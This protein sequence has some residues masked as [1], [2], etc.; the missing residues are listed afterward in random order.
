MKLDRSWEKDGYIL[1]PAREE[2]AERYFEQNFNP[3]DREA[4]R[5]TGSKASFTRE[6]VVSFLRKAVHAEDQY[7]FLLISPDGRM[8]GESV[9]KSGLP[10]GGH[11][12]GRG[13]GR[14]QLCRRYPD[15]AA[16]RR[17]ERDK[18]R[19]VT[20]VLDINQW[21][22]QYTAAVRGAFG[23][24]IRFIG[25]QGSRG[26]G[27]AKESSDIDVVLILDRLDSEDL[28]TYRSAVEALPE[29]ALLCGFVCGWP[30][31]VRWEKSDLLSLLLDTK[32]ICGN[33]SGLLETIGE[34]DFRRAVL[35]ESKSLIDE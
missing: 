14:G 5:L 20:A 2:D 31:L 28:N 7:L 23:E 6:E 9:F 21:M 19:G 11:P 34:E 15:G 4:A 27:E 32:P 8:I 33:L 17:V 10:P 12:A 24:R 3:L 22:D 18:E 16:G 30:E 1:R 26:R 25:L 29:R 35:A 13:P